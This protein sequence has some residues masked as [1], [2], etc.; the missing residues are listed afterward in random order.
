MLISLLTID[1]IAYIIIVVNYFDKLFYNREA[2]IINGESQFNIKK[3]ILTTGVY[4]KNT[5]DNYGRLVI[6]ELKD[7]YNHQ[8]L[9]SS[10]IYDYNVLNDYEQIFDPFDNRLI[11]NSKSKLRKRINYN[12]DNTD[13]VNYI[14][15]ENEFIAL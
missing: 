1:S 4:L 10:F 9:E 7:S 13:L 6:S 5:Y 15:E 14:E 2:L 12:Y 11:L 8:I 3:A